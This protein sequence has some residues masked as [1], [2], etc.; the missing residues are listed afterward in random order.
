MVLQQKEEVKLWGWADAG[1]QVQVKTSWGKEG[2]AVADAEGKWSIYIKTPK[3]CNGQWV[4]VLSG[5]DKQ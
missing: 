4:E 1:E 5:K 2:Q 3:C